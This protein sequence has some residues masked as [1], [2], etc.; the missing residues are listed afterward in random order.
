ML[1]ATGFRWVFWG[2]WILV[3]IHSNTRS[4]PKPPTCGC[5]PLSSLAPITRLP[6]CPPSHSTPLPLLAPALPPTPSFSFPV[7][8][9][10]LPSFPLL[11]SSL[12][13]PLCFLWMTVTLSGLGRSAA[14]L[15]ISY[16]S[17]VSYIS[18]VQYR[19]TLFR[20][21]TSANPGQE[22]AIFRDSVSRGDLAVWRC[23]LLNRALVPSQGRLRCAAM[24]PN[25]YLWCKNVPVA[26]GNR[27]SRSSQAGV[28][29]QCACAW[30]VAG[31]RAKI[32][33]H[34]A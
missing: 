14:R 23:L 22:R 12:S 7:S 5:I 8:L 11:P 32:W 31:S 6:G 1:L 20:K 29:K 34:F 30:G 13:L 25:S 24:Y 4:L 15:R 10:S 18:C 33:Q 21:L 9:T 16:I 26:P 3:S 27:L 28:A 19:E 2:T 17:Q